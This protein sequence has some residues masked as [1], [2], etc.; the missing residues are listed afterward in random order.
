MNEFKLT[1]LA[2]HVLR[3]ELVAAGGVRAAADARELAR[4]AEFDARR[5]Y[6]PEGYASMRQFCVAELKYTTDE[7][8]ARIRVARTAYDFPAIFRAY[9]AKMAESLGEAIRAQGQLVPDAFT[10]GAG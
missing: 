4:V 7:A 9:A 3:Q 6:L 5:L 1:H 10:V 8:H 2:N